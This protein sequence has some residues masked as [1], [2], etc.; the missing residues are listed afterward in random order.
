MNRPVITL[1]T[2]FGTRDSYVG[3]VKGVLLSRC[4]DATIVDISH[5]VEPQSISE[6]AYVLATGAKYYPPDAIHIAVVDPGVGSDRRPIAVQTPCGTFV[7]PDNGILSLAIAEFVRAPEATQEERLERHDNRLALTHLN[8][9]EEC[10]GAVLN[11]PSY[12]LTEVSRT[13]HGRDVF[14]PVAA[15]L[16]SGVPISDLGATLEEIRVMTSLLP[17]GNGE[18][19]G[20]IVHIDRYGNLI[21]NIPEH[22]VPEEAAFE[23]AGHRVTGLSSSYSEAV[24]KIM[25]IIGSQGTVEIALGNGNAAEA[26]NA[27]VGDTVAIVAYTP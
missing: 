25:A 16:A 12:W 22:D 4:P 20:T 11:D 27:S 5:Q 3:A 10:R 21:T 1:T 14:A 26:L 2:D 23:V 18:S 15:H 19:G 24:G 8:L 13:F 7:A 17:N 6:G 9:S